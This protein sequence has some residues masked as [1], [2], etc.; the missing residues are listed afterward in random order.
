MRSNSLVVLFKES[1][2]FTKTF[3]WNLSNLLGL[4]HK[5]WI[6]LNNSFELLFLNIENLLERVSVSPPLL[7]TIGKD[8]LEEDS[9]GNRPSGSFQQEHAT[10]ILETDIKFN[11]FLLE[12]VPS[13]NIVLVG[14]IF[15]LGSVPTAIAR[16]FL[17]IKINFERALW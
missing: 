4:L 8:P 12:I 9:I 2:K 7:E 14:E 3:F 11:T 15:L 17:L 13:S 10:V 1:L 16:Q 6:F 5:Y